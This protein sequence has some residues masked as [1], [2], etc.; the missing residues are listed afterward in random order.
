MTPLQ[1][2]EFSKIE[3]AYLKT[4]Y[5]N[6]GSEQLRLMEVFF[7]WL[8][9]QLDISRTAVAL[10]MSDAGKVASLSRKVTDAQKSEFTF[11]QMAMITA[12]GRKDTA[13]MVDVEIKMRAWIDK[14]LT[15]AA[16]EEFKP[17]MKIVGN[18]QTKK[19]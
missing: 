9:K 3:L 11:L 2:E 16:N 6:D 13:Q 4:V 8:K 18:G 5:G 17:K 15:A 7:F 10:A 19:G 12:A 14:Q 1:I